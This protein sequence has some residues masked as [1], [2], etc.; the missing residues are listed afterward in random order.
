MW[1]S[2]LSTKDVQYRCLDIKNFYLSTPLD[3]YKYMKMQLALLPEWMQMQ[4]N[5][6]KLALNRFVYLEM[7]RTVWGHLQAGILANKFLQ[8]HLLPHRYF[9]CPNTPG[10]W[11]HATH[12]ILFTL[13]ADNFGVKYVGKEH[14]DHLIK[15]IKMKYKHTKEWVGDLYCGIKLNWDYPTCTLD[16]SMPGYITKLLQKYKH[17]IPSKPQR[18][19]CSVLSKQYGK[20]A[21]APISVDISPKL[22]L[23]NI[24]QI[25]QIVG[26]ILYYARAVD[27]TVLM[28]LSSIATK[29][30]KGMTNTMEKTKLLLDYLATNPDATIWY[31][32]SDMIMN[33]HSDA[34]YLSEAGACNRAWGHF[35]H[36]LEHNRRQPHQAQW[37]F[38]YLVC[39]SSLHCYF[40]HRSQTWSPI[41]KLQRRHDISNDTRRVGSP[42]TKNTDP[43]GWCHRH[44]YC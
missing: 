33:V 39:H 18:C 20:Q 26:S 14:V 31:H 42:S 5:L 38:L 11:K 40:C 8:K 29:Q 41:S 27:I 2:A 16:I 37:C 36:G 43:L 22:S 30:R 21:Q 13:V 28:A 10:L 25:Q 17:C 19:P 1:N 23:D 9:K 34:S 3:W 32:M 24:K 12:P 7:C 6:D 44:W 15:C 4:Y 35:F